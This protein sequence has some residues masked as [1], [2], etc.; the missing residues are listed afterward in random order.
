M[1]ID[2]FSSHNWHLFL[3][4]LFSSHS[5]FPFS[6]SLV[7]PPLPCQL[8]MAF[9]GAQKLPAG[10]MVMVDLLV[11]SPSL[12]YSSSPS[13]SPSFHWH[14]FL[15]L[16]FPF[17]HV[18]WPH[19]PLPCQLSMNFL[20]AHKLPALVDSHGWS[21]SGLF[22]PL[23]FLLLLP[24]PSTLSLS[25]PLLDFAWLYCSCE[26]CD[27]TS[28]NH[29]LGLYQFPELQLSVFNYTWMTLGLCSYSTK[30]FCWEC[31]KKSTSTFMIK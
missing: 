1:I 18:M 10:S 17:L 14:L 7:P 20:G 21:T 15:T 19:T 31:Y 5:S 28:S 16:P 4:L 22:F 8:S 24:S 30:E 26:S 11:D 27:P 3:A 25:D 6:L 23:L 2:I 9:L 29:H 13:L 12:Y